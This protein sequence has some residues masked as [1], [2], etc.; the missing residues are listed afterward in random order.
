[1][2][3]RI[4]TSRDGC[5][6]EDAGLSSAD[7][8]TAEIV[9]LAIVRPIRPDPLYVLARRTSSPFPFIVRTERQVM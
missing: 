8:G 4:S 3:Y 1:M 9:Q 6:D 2:S 7:L 5:P